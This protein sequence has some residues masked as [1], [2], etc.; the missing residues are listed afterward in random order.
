MNFVALDSLL[1][2]YLVAVT[3]LTMAPGADTLLVLRAALVRGR[4]VAVVTSFG[5]CCGLFIHAALSALGISAILARSATA[6]ELLKL[7][8]AAYLVYLGIAALREAFARPRQ[9]GAPLE[10]AAGSDTPRPR[11]ACA[12]FVEG[13]LNNVLNPK[14]AVFYLAFLPQFIRAGDPVMLKS[15]FLAGVHFLVGMLWLGMLVWLV[16]NAR[17]WLERPAVKRWLEGVSGAMLLGLGLQ[18]ALSRGR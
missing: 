5:I 17:R 16:G 15:L 14:A 4:R 6:F 12:A 1:L 7:A 3:L 2:T 9:A 18:L 10:P 11:G 8:G 13:L